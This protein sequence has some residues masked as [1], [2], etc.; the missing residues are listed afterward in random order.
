MRTGRLAVS[1]VALLGLLLTQS[2][3]AEADPD[4]AKLR[5]LNQQ[6]TALTKQYRGE[7]Q[8]LE[9][10]KIQV[11]KANAR[12]AALTRQLA[13]A[14]GDV[15]LIAQSNYI[16]GPIDSTK[17]LNYGGDPHSALGLAAS[18]SYLANERAG[19]LARL[20]ELIAEAKK[21][22]AAASAK[23]GDLEKEIKA[24]Q[25]KRRDIER[26][27]AKYGFQQTI[28][29]GGLTP[30][31]TAV[32]DAVLSQFLV[33]STGCFRAGDP[34]EHGK[35][36]ACDFMMTT[37]GQMATGDAERR[38]DELAQWLINNGSRLGVMYIIWKQRYYD[39]RGG[40]GWDPMS[41]RGG[42]TAN[43]WDHVHVSVF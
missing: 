9:E 26:L 7:I 35:G 32:K 40:G 36:R 14:Q 25:N 3:P 39:I 5:R 38:G 15:T 29:T 42:V 37:G 41:D 1:A 16:N 24:M 19:R 34:G 17:L 23:I 11:K 30:R 43:H 22:K 20:R 2:A 12:A 18:M 31:M 8:S 28:G 4:Q 6:A 33:P 27:L 13:S 10:A 21:A